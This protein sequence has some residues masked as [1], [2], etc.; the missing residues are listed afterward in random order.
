MQLQDI[1]GGGGRPTGC[2]RAT[3]CLPPRYP[4]ACYCLP[5]LSAV[6]GACLPEGYPP[7][8]ACYCLQM[9]ALSWWA[10]CLCISIR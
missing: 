8:T 1:A 7:A 9:F 4:G 5:P 3:A 2:V 10:A 6:S